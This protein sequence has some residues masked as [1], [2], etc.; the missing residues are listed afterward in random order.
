LLPLTPLGEEMGK[1][2]TS[3][4]PLIL[5]RGDRSEYR[6]ALRPCLDCSYHAERIFQFMFRA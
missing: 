1:V 3:I 6:D 5:P 2:W 4:F